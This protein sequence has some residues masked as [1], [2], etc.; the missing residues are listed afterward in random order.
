MQKL[1]PPS[2]NWKENMKFKSDRLKK[3]K[4]DRLNFLEKCGELGKAGER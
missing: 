4:S 3:K 2:I 1:K